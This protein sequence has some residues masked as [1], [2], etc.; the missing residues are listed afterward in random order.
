MNECSCGTI[1]VSSA[2][3][4]GRQALL[5]FLIIFSGTG[6]CSRLRKTRWPSLLRK[7]LNL[8]TYCENQPLIQNTSSPTGQQSWHIQ[9]SS[10]I[11]HYSLSAWYSNILDA[12]HCKGWTF[13]VW[14][15]TDKKRRAT[16]L[17]GRNTSMPTM[18]W[19][20]VR[21]SWDPQ[22]PSLLLGD[23]LRALPTFTT[24]CATDCTFIFYESAG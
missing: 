9:Y 4:L 6:S 12:G 20:S 7:K 10:S 18:Q 22:H 8:H 16:P 2:I 17:L 11:M 14:R 3:F 13:C 24:R 21:I 23:K 19:Y 15:P 5:C 1:Q